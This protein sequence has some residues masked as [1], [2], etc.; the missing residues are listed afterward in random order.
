MTFT[1]EQL[2]QALRLDAYPRSAQYDPQWV[3]CNLM[4]PN[5]LWLAE[6]L[7]ERLELRPGMRVLDMGCGKAL[8]SIF[9]AREFGVQV[10]ANDLWISATENWGRIRAA[11]LESSVFP[12]HAEAHALP[13]A[14]GFFDAIVSVDAYHYFGT[15]D[16]YIGEI[17]RFLRPG[18]AIGVVSPG[19]SEEFDVTPEHLQPHWEWDFVSFHSP[20]WWSR[21]WARTGKVQVECADLLPD[22][23]KH[24]LYWLEICE[25]AGAHRAPDEAAMLR[26]DA[27]HTLGFARIVA[28]IVA[29]KV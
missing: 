11:G 19:L 6:A 15:D 28:R 23:W 20:A 24:W 27:G 10:W 26:A 1:N 7:C 18:G 2:A 29:R 12:I 5:P 17:T 14:E 3:M 13:Y 22:G 21:H 9:L 16:L 25:A 8:T 4:G